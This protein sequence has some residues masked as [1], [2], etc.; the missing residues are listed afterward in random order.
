MGRSV[1]VRGPSQ[2]FPLAYLVAY[3][4]PFHLHNHPATSWVPTLDVNREF[5]VFWCS[6]QS[7]NSL[8]YLSHFV[9]LSLPPLTVVHYQCLRR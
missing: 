3:I 4:G 7:F 1:H 9:Y 2:W 6:H 8:R 5:D